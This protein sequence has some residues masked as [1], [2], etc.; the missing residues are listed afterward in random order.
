MARG[1]AIVIGGAVAKGAFA[2]GALAELT[3]K[4]GEKGVPIRRLVGTSSG[5]LNATML[6]GGVR[7]GDPVAAA[8]KL[9]HLWE[10]KAN[11]WHVFEP[12]LSSWVHGRG[13]S[14]THRIVDLLRKECP[15]R[16][17]APPQ[18]VSLRIVVSP[19]AGV[20]ARRTT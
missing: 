16:G 7:A 13:A 5:A 1:A 19:L 2:A 11:V 8:D 6:A 3:M 14:G 17:S 10:E 12:D 15:A 9:T 4:L 18:H 20:G